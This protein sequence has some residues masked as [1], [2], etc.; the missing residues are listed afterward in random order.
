MQIYRVHSQILNQHPGYQ[1]SYQYGS[2]VNKSSYIDTFDLNKHQW[3]QS[4]TSWK[5][6]LIWYRKWKFKTWVTWQLGWTFP[7]FSW[8]FFETLASLH[9]SSLQWK[10]QAYLGDINDTLEVTFTIHSGTSKN[11]FT[12]SA[13]VHES[14]R[15]HSRH[16]QVKLMWLLGYL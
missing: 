8:G 1:Y 15:L 3:E 7:F 13:D 11:I 12:H 14:F 16:I 5:Q 6:L 2:D 9:I 4:L 10:F